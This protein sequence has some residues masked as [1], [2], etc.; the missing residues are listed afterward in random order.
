MAGQ[1]DVVYQLLAWML[2]QL[3][4]FKKRS[5]LARFLV[6]VEVPEEILQNEEVGI[7]FDKYNVLLETFKQV[8]RQ[9]DTL[10]NSG[11]SGDDIRKDISAMEAELGNLTR[12]TD[13]MREKAQ[14]F[15]KYDEMLAQAQAL[16]AQ[17]E[18]ADQLDLQAEDQRNQ[19]EK[20]S[21]RHERALQT[22][23]EVRQSSVVG[24]AAGLMARI[25]EENKMLT[26]LASEKNPQAIQDS[27]R[28][29]G[30]LQE[31][32][33]LPSMFQDDLQGLNDQIKQLGGE[34]NALIEKRMVAQAGP[35]D[36][37]V[38]LF[39]QQASIIANKKEATADRLQE[40]QDEVAALESQLAEKRSQS[41]GPKMLKA[42]EFKRY[43]AKLR[44]KSTTYKAK[45]A[46]LQDLRSEYL[47]LSRTDEIL[48]KQ[49]GELEEQVGS[50]EQAAGVSGHHDMQNQLA[51]VS[52]QT[53]QVNAEKELTLESIG[54][55]VQELTATIAAKKTALAPL[56]TQLREAR[57][58]AEDLD[59]V[60]QE[61]KANYDRVA[62][63]LEGTK[64]RLEGE[65]RELREVVGQEEAR[66]HYLN[67][68]IDLLKVQEQSVHDEVKKYT[69]GVHEHDASSKPL[70]DIYGDR[71]HKGESL[72]K[73]LREKQKL[74][75]RDH[76]AN[77]Q[78][79]DTWRDLSLLMKCKVK[80][81]EDDGDDGEGA[82]G[83]MEQD[84]LVL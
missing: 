2:P 68:M 64:G 41:K 12:R 74:V 49:L 54:E 55:M 37:K 27:E 31:V 69:Q 1:K 38:A 48:K 33:K 39:R 8:H 21:K 78:L 47:V 28:Q 53:D 20:V 57:A 66:Y 16:R 60:Y 43:V 42:D 44:S 83:G 65:V 14:S 84:R 6:R 51:E 26:F 19:I 34:I 75:K 3:E 25:E 17:Q 73:Q 76:E 71:V 11:F 10:K 82:V 77:M 35:G 29:L 7:V 62:S 23:K 15:P 5:Y 24:G 58:K 9:C 79:L 56:I 4:A 18:R 67:T 50:A 59:S 80:L 63:S 13:R 70:R 45:K 72:G 30:E 36:D 52:E 40:Q 61:K 46:E 22:L 81:S 32:V